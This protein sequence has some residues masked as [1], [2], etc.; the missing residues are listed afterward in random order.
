[1][2]VYSDITHL[3]I[4]YLKLIQRDYATIKQVK[5][6]LENMPKKVSRF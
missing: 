4:S 3:N 1:M 2:M 5:S 6:T